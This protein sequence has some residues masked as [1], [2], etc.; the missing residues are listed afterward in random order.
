MPLGAS[1]FLARC[2]EDSGN[3]KGCNVNSRGWQP[4]VAPA[5]PGD[6]A[7]VEP[8]AGPSRSAPSGPGGTLAFRGLTPTAIQVET[9]RVSPP[10]A[11]HLQKS[12]MRRVP[13]V[14][15]GGVEPKERCR[16]ALATAVQHLRGLGGTG[17]RP[18][19]PELT[20]GTPVPL[21]ELTGE[22]PVPLAELAG[23]TPVPLPELTG[24][25][26]PVQQGTLPGKPAA[27]RVFRL[28]T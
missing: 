1:Q 10:L 6:P 2:E 4:T 11:R 8:A 26:V 13:L 18:H 22:T 19:E 15:L 24:E 3:P 23:G 17:S 16:A 9:L 12:E 27:F 28:S 7:R 5:R 25:C 14:A 20:G 21:P